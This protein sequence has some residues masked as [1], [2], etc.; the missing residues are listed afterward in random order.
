MPTSD[1]RSEDGPAKLS[2]NAN[3]INSSLENQKNI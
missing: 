2:A 1:K 3:T